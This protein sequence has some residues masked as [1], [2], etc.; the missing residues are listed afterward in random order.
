MAA[1]WREEG[2]HPVGCTSFWK[3]LCTTSIMSPNRLGPRPCSSSILRH[4][5]VR[6]LSSRTLSARTL[7]RGSKSTTSQRSSKLDLIT[8]SSRMAF[9]KPQAC[10]RCPP[11]SSTQKETNPNN[12][13]FITRVWAELLIWVRPIWWD[14]L[15]MTCNT[16]KNSISSS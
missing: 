11:N 3:I 8:K 13:T 1:R 6:L 4:K 5:T 7:S 14:H 2:R 12:L 9:S 10:S 16:W 15:K